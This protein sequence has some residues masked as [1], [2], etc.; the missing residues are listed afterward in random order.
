M[1]RED[2]QAAGNTWTWA[3]DEAGNILNKKEYAYTTGALGSVLSTVTYGYPSATSN[4]P[5]K[6]LLVSYN[7]STITYDTIGNPLSDG[8][9]NYTWKQGR[10]LAQMSN[11]TTTWA[12]TYD[13]AGLRT[14]R[15]DGTT[16]YTYVYSEGQL[17]YMKKTVGSTSYTFIFRY[18]ADGR[19]YSVQYD[20][21]V[22]F[23]VLNAQG[24]VLGIVDS[25][26]ANVAIY[27]YDAWG[28]VLSSSSSTLA[29]LNPL[30]YR[31]YVY[32]QETGLYYLQSRYYNPEWGRFISPDNYPTTGQGVTGNNMFV[33]CGNNPVMRADSQGEFWN[34]IVGAVVGGAI[35]FVSTL[36][37]ELVNNKGEIDTD[38]WKKIGV[39]TALGV[40]EGAL[41]AL[42][43]AAAIAIS[44]A[45]SVTETAIHGVIDGDSVG[46]I[47][48]DSLIS[49][50]IG[51]V[52]GSGGT[53]FVK[54][55][56]LMNQAAHSL[57]NA[58]RKGVHPVVKKAAKKTVKKA[59][60]TI[61]RE[62]ASGQIE[63]LLY[64][65]ITFLTKRGASTLF[66]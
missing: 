23:Y 65:Q 10:Q 29:Q 34:V 39:S 38:S 2:N 9:W 50:A 24:D 7:G 20:G 60:K 43:P 18:G 37:S 53:E 41:V 58:V 22:Y 33:Y 25:N 16:T 40:A 48:R 59:I 56:K 61:G 17:R 31:G 36:V 5:W 51:A 64:E 12:Y 3:Y 26:G 8:T 55:G 52:A 13:D 28:N 4:E 66:A 47:V 1:I 63:D 44:A 15:T 30:R 32:D 57:G 46:K 42:C 6:D 49:G 14:Q 19:P 35:S 21:E 62:F 11:G 54:G 27:A 45:S